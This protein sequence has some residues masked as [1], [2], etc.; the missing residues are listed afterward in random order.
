MTKDLNK[1]ITDISYNSLN[2]PKQLTINGTTHTYTYAADGRKLKVTQGNTERDYAG[3]VIYENGSLKR[4][5]IEGGY[6][7]GGVYYFYLNDHLG[8]T[9][10]VAN[11]S[12]T[13]I[14]RD[15]YYP[16]GL[17]MAETSDTEQ[18]KQPYKYNG[19]EFERK[20][21]L[22]WMDYGARNYDA[23]MGRFTTM[24]PHAETYYNWSPY[25]YAANNP[26]LVTDPT[27]MDWYSYDEDYVDEK[28]G[29]TKKR[30]QYRYVE[31]RMSNKE[32]KEGGYTHLGLTYSTDDK[33]YSLFGSTVDTNTLQGDLYKLV[34]N[35]IIKDAEYKSK[36]LDK[37]NRDLE[38]SRPTTDFTILGM[39]A[40]DSRYLGLDSRRNEY[41]FTYEGSSMGVYRVTNGKNSMR[42][43]MRDWI[44]DSD[45]PKVIGGYLTNSKSAYHIR[46]MN[47]LGRGSDIIHLKF[48]TQNSSNLLSKYYKLFPRL[49]K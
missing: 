31:G 40:K 22:N 42:G 5:L 27:G 18:N 35:A 38:L 12:G 30:T 36:L 9:R 47:D 19:K 43:K 17:P 13:A 14:Q 49:K 26:M 21:G 7:E 39:N 48:G 15:H 23:G 25:H 3:S 32:M 29:E 45:M 46:F 34:D 20:D 33:Y 44:G 4:I 1:K 37:N 16:F 6:I 24:D 10:V 11:A 8:N 2:L 28:D 41:S